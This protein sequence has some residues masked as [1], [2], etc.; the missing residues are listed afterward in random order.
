MQDAGRVFRNGHT[1][2]PIGNTRIPIGQPD[3]ETVYF[4]MVIRVLSTCRTNA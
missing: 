3:E 1:H 2:L 4:L